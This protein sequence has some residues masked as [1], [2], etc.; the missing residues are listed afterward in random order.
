MFL[1]RLLFKFKS[2]LQL[3]LGKGRIS[4][5][6][7]GEDRIILFLLQTLGIKQ[8]T[9]LDIGANDP[10]EGNNTYLFFLLGSTGICVEPDPDLF[11]ALIAKRPSDQCLNI[12][13]NPEGEGLADFYIF[14]NPYKGWNTFSK[15]EALN[16]ENQSNVKP[17]MV[18]QITMQSI[19]KV[20]EERLGNAPDIL[21]IDIEGL[22][23]AVLRSID[24]KKFKPIIICAET[25]KFDVGNK[26]E[27]DS[28]I[29]MYLESNGYFVYADTWVNTIFCLKS[30]F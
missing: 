9:Y 22:D 27:K 1:K 3:F 7:C 19:N 15:E 5:S 24:F 21:S 16:R 29:R 13:I 26:G 23:S 18:S 17:T 2:S 30:Y 6:Q 14:P 8:P 12:G 25:V 4:F 11:D 28:E 10:I 20:M